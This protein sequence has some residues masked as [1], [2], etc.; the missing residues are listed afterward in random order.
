MLGTDIFPVCRKD[1]SGILGL[2]YLFFLCNLFCSKFINLPI[3][4]FGIMN[5]V[6]RCDFI[7]H[8]IGVAVQ[9]SIRISGFEM[10]IEITDI[11]IRDRFAERWLDWIHREKI[12]VRVRIFGA[13]LF[14]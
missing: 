4:F 11:L 5:S 6:D 13:D 14:I 10:G 3:T 1:T 7:D 8:E 12:K 9:I 2:R